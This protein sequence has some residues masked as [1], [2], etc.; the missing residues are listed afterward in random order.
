MTQ[1]LLIPAPRELTLAKGTLS[2]ANNAYIRIPSRETFFTGQWLQSTLQENGLNWQIVVS[3][4][5]DSGGIVLKNNDSLSEQAYTLTINASGIVLEGTGAGLFYAA[6]T[7]K[8]LIMQYGQSLPHLTISDS[9]DYPARGVMIDISRDKVPTMETLFALV[10]DFA[11]LKINQLQLYIEHTF[12]YVGHDDVWQRASPMT[13]QDILALDAYC[14]ERFIDLVPNQNSLGHMERWLKHP[15]YLHMAESP[16][17][18]TPFWDENWRPASTLDPQDEGSFELIT[19]LYD[20]YLPHFSSDLFNVGCD[21]PWEL[22]QG[23]S[24]E[25]VEERGGRV[26]LD[27]MLKLYEDVTGRGKQMMFWGD[28]INHHPDLVPELPDDVIVMEWGYEADHDFE[29]HCKVFAESGIPFYVCP[30]TSSWNTLIGRTTNTMGNLK[31]A[32]DNGLKYGAIGYL[33]T[34]WGDNGHMQPLPVSWLGFS[35]GAAVSWER[36]NNTEIDLTDA[37]SRF[38]FRD[39]A[40]MMGQLA[41]DFGNAYLELEWNNFNGHLL[42][43]LTQVPHQRDAA[44]K[45]NG[46]KDKLPAKHLKHMIS[47]LS[48]LK[49]KLSQTRMSRPDADLIIKEYQQAASLVQHTAKWLLFIRDESD[50]SAQDLRQELDTLIDNQRDVWLGRNRR[51]GLEDSIRRLQSMRDDYQS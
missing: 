40:N 48:G 41:H 3:D 8:Q 1:P 16:D 33:N 13:P 32:A 6:T 14:R 11:L 19:S 7:L 35:Y 44:K 27:W 21:E 25:A 47:H 36:N 24:K 30:G 50:Q 28:I 5:V 29:G 18:F 15:Q 45:E 20:Q 23:K 9:P 43:Y 17:G 46:F 12:A 38:V 39:E 49:A 4:D 31:N 26:Y 37:L 22:G 42:S 10:D 34:D 51:G 2:L